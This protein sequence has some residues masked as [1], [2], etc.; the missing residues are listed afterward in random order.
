MSRD[1]APRLKY[2]KPAMIY[3]GF[4]PALQG[5]QT[6]MSA[7]D[8]NSC[9]YISDTPKQIEKKVVLEGATAF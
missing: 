1:A 8:E 6:K 2:E 3:S 9:I 5:A 7:S 4:L